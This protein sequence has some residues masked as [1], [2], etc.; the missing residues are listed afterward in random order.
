MIAEQP[1]ILDEE[2]EINDAG[3]PEDFTF[4]QVMGMA[5]YFHFRPIA[6]AAGREY[7]ATLCDDCGEQLGECDGD[8]KFD[9]EQEAD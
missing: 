1:D 7:L 9:S 3:G 4:D 6:D 2:G 8:H 5:I